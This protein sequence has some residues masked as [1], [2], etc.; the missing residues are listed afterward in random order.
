MKMMYKILWLSIRWLELTALGWKLTNSKQGKLLKGIVN[1]SG[2]AWPW[3]VSDKIHKKDCNFESFCF[4][5]K[6]V[7]LRREH[8]K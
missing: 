5:I 2:A 8:T 3:T 6:S 1:W 4:I 7:L